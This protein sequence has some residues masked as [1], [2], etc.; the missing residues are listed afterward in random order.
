MAPRDVPEHIGAGAGGGG[1]DLDIQ[2]GRRVGRADADKARVIDRERGGRRRGGK[3]GLRVHPESIGGVVEDPGRRGGGRA[4]RGIDELDPRRRSA[5]AE[6]ESTSSPACLT[7]RDCHM[8]A[9]PDGIGHRDAQQVRGRWVLGEDAV[10]RF[11]PFCQ[12]GRV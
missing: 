12:I 8:Y 9:V 5:S 7:G 10:P 1:L 4:Q 3:V 6:E 11:P 2:L